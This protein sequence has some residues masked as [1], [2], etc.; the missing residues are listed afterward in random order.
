MSKCMDCKHWNPQHTAPGMSR[1]GFAMCLKKPTPGRTFSAHAITCEQ[2]KQATAE[3][4]DA[5]HAKWD[6]KPG[7]RNANA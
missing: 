2:F 5:R 1:L 6:V 3:I 7:G 4:A